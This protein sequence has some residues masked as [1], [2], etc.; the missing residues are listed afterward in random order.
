MAQPQT[1]QPLGPEG[2]PGYIT[3]TG[4]FPRNLKGDLRSEKRGRGG[5]RE[6]NPFPKLPSFPCE[7]D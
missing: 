6:G 1:P 3:L 2:S 5:E 7:L 4:S